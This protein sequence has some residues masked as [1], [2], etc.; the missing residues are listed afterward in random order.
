MATGM[1][2]HTLIVMAQSGNTM[3]FEELV[4]RYDKQVL[5]IAMSYCG[6]EE[7]A[8]DIYQE[9][10]I[11]VFGPCLSFSSRVSFRHGCTVSSSMCV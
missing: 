1:D 10:F 7:E 11:R 8:K 5:S 4:Y 2:D 9:V 6:H 3:A